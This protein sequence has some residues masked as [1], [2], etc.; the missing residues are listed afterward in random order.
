MW[1]GMDETQDLKG[2]EGDEAG[3]VKRSDCKSPVNFLLTR[4]Y[5]I[6]E[7]MENNKGMVFDSTAQLLP[8]NNTKP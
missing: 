5:L 2:E 4:L 1:T 6:W 8:R 3:N 7:T